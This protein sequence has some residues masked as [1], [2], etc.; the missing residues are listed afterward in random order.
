MSERIDYSTHI[1]I[2]IKNSGD[3]TV[4]AEWPYVPRQA[5]VDGKIQAVG[6]TYKLFVLCTP[7]S[8]YTGRKC[9]LSKATA[10]A[11]KRL[12]GAVVTLNEF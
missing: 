8:I 6:K 1:L 4:V 9:S 10:L 2:G 5:D 3:M 7:T 12:R 11:V